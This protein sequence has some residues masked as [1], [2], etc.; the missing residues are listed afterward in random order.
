[1]TLTRRRII[2]ATTPGVRRDPCVPAAGNKRQLF[3][4]AAGE[5]ALGVTE[6]VGP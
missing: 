6:T 4:A 1:M 3:Y 5:D 2:D